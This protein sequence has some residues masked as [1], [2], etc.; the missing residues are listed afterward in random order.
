MR[1][2]SVIVDVA[3]GVAR[4]TLNRPEAANT[5]DLTLARELMEASLE[6]AGN[7]D[8]RAVLLTGEGR[9][10]CGG[11]DLKSFRAHDGPLDRHLL[12]VTT[13]LHAA[14]SRMSRLAVPVVAAVQG[15]A[16]GAGVG[17][18]CSADIVIAAEST[19]FVMAYKQVGLS[20]DG[21]ATW[22]LPRIVGLRRALELMLTN[23]VLGAAEAMSMGLITEVVPEAELNERAALVAK[24]LAEG[25]TIALG[26]TRRLLRQ[27]L[28]ETLE[29]QMELESLALAA[30]ARTGDALEGIAAFLEKRDPNFKGR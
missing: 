1:P 7:Q 15:S 18:A 10:F 6:V 21:S 22:L 23:R 9:V 30:S 14:L 28:D 8:I 12:E 27:S 11:G 5:I 24:T 26:N 19:R 25:P 29:S 13:Y 16:A 17:L 2:S 3:E 20:P 4:V